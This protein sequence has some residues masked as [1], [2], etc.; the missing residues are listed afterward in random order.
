MATPLPE[1][2]APLA[3]DLPVNTMYTAPPIR[4]APSPSPSPTPSPSPSV[5]SE[6]PAEAVVAAEAVLPVPVSLP[7]PVLT[8][9]V[10]TL[11]PYAEL[12]AV[13]MAVVKVAVGAVAVTP[14][15]PAALL[16]VTE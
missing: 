8:T 16:P 6:V 14:A 12:K 11:E 9:V 5:C 7:L 13:A 2:A 15:T 4:R 1:A 10:V 3:A